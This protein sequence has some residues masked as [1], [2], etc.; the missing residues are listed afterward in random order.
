M[1]DI[2]FGTLLFFFGILFG[3]FLA[4]LAHA[5]LFARRVDDFIAIMDK[6][7]ARLDKKNHQALSKELLDLAFSEA[8]WSPPTWTMLLLEDILLR[9]GVKKWRNRIKTE[10]V[11]R[12]LGE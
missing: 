6:F 4:H 7:E 12:D 11:R 2:T 10:R 1:N 9:I 3:E 8:C 5:G